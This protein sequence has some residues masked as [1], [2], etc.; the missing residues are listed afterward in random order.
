[1]T[2]ILTQ[3]ETLHPIVDAQR[4][5]LKLADVLEILS[6]AEDRVKSSFSDTGGCLGFYAPDLDPGLTYKISQK[7]NAERALNLLLEA[8]DMLIQ[9][10][11]CPENL[12]T[13]AI[14]F[15]RSLEK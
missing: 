8:S 7:Q 9:C 10:C 12:R 6:E 1:M 11:E 15:L 4:C 2:E 5:R 14:A 3:T 13:H